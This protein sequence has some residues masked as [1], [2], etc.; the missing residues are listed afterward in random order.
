MVKWKWEVL[1]VIWLVTWYLFHLLKWD[2][3]LI[4]ASA[5][6]QLSP[7]AVLIQS[8]LHTYHTSRIWRSAREWWFIDLNQKGWSGAEGWC[9]RSP[10]LWL[11]L[12]DPWQNQDSGN[13]SPLFFY[14]DHFRCRILLSGRLGTLSWSTPWV[15]SVLTFNFSGYLDFFHLESGESGWKK[16]KRDVWPRFDLRGIQ[17]WEYILPMPCYRMR[18]S[19]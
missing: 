7:A 12:A 13:A 4:S 15:F 8:A 18:W 6:L 17:Y 19:W 2:M 1:N 14:N 9:R 5:G 3:T 11:N 16:S 10:L